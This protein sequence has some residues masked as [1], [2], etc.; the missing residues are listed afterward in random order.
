[1]TDYNADF[2]LDE[3]VRSIPFKVLGTG[4]VSLAKIEI[5]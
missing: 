2:L 1:V 3:E 4:A 5:V